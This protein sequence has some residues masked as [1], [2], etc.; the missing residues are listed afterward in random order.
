MHD[1]IKAPLRGVQVS[2]DLL[3]AHQGVEFLAIT[4][5]LQDILVAEWAGTVLVAGAWVE[6]LGRSG[7]NVWHDGLFHKGTKTFE[8]QADI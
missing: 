1:G 4:G 5:Q 2:R 7:A 3:L 6:K 8:R